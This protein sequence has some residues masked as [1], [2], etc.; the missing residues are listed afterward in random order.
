MNELTELLDC[1]AAGLD[2]AAQFRLCFVAEDSRCI[3]RRLAGRDTVPFRYVDKGALA[4]IGR[5]A[6]VADFGRLRFAGFF[7][8]LLWWMVHVFFLISFRN[9][10]LVM[11]HWA[12]SWVTF[13]RGARL[14]TGRTPELPE[15][16]AR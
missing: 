1:G 4:T 12:W 13:Q 16:G 2:D 3:R 6:A 11:F 10:L 8:W 15:L 7:A 5:S 9:R 14:I